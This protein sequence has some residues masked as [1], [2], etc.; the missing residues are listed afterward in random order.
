[1]LTS[2]L[3]NYLRTDVNRLT[4]RF[5]LKGFRFSVNQKLNV[6][7][8]CHAVVK[9]GNTEQGFINRCRIHMTRDIVLPCLALVRHQQRTTFICGP[10]LQEKV[11][12]NLENSGGV[13][14]EP[15]EK[16]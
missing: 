16:E 5:C 3:N 13:N 6:N 12:G 7:Q 2:K 15:T 1:M 10:P 14:K 9:M 4:N 11:I 8:L